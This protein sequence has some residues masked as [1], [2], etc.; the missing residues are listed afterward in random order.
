MNGWFSLRRSI[1]LVGVVTALAA[2]TACEASFSTAKISDAWMST[3]EEGSERVTSYPP[4]AAFFA[5]VDVSN[6]PDD[7]TL[8][9]SWI[10]VDVEGADPGLVIDEVETTTGSG[11]AFFTL[12]NDGPWP[13]GTYK[14]DIHLN[15]ELDRTLEFS[16]Q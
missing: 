10:A 2:L 11:V 15:G 7:T 16:V 6:A 14:V 8:K 13:P 5:Q 12:T 1:A 3:D 4:D 9:T